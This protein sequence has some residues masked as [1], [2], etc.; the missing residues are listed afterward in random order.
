MKGAENRKSVTAHFQ[1]V[2]ASHP[3][4]HSFKDIDR[5]LSKERLQKVRTQGG[6]RQIKEPKKAV[7]NSLLFKRWRP[8]IQ[9]VTLSKTRTKTF[10]KRGCKKCALW[11]GLNK[12]K[13]QKIGSQL[14]PNSK[15][16]DIAKYLTAS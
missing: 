13:E 3:V 4:C 10:P 16:Q 8:A 15:F 1:R 14:Q 7:N 5:K 6:V 11:A 12:L 2:E 9:L